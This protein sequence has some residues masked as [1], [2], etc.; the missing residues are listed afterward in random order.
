MPAHFQ[1]ADHATRVLQ[2]DIMLELSSDSTLS[3][4]DTAGQMYRLSFSRHGKLSD[5]FARQIVAVSDRNTIIPLE[6]TANFRNASNQPVQYIGLN[7]HVR[8][9]FNKV[10]LAHIREFRLQTRPYEWAEFRNVQLQPGSRD[11]ARTVTRR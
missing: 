6:S 11:A 8:D 4:K 9:W 5:D 3:Y 2:D 10:D 7:I 1:R